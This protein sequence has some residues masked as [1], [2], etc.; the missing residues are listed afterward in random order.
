[1][2]DR[3]TCRPDYF[4]C[5]PGL[6]PHVLNQG[7]GDPRRQSDSNASL[8]VDAPFLPANNQVKQ[9]II[10]GVDFR[11]RREWQNESKSALSRGLKRTSV[12]WRCANGSKKMTTRSF[13]RVALPPGLW[14]RI[15]PWAGRIQKSTAPIALASFRMMEAVTAVSVE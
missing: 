4:W 8:A 7:V 6:K 5:R 11:I 3:G 12:V 10:T 13:R 1:M 14:D 15:A 2:L 9:A